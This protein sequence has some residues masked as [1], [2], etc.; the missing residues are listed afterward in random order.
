[1]GTE[2]SSLQPANPNQQSTMQT[3]H[4]LFVAVSVGFMAFFFTS[5]C[6]MA[7]Y[8][9]PFSNTSK[10][11][12]G[13]VVWVT[14]ASSGIGAS[15]AKDFTVRGAE[16]IVSAR[17]VAELEAIAKECT[18][19][20]AKSVKVLPLDVLDHTAQQAA[21]D[22]IISEFGHVD[23]LVL[24]PGRTQRA[25]AL[26]T[27]IESTRALFDLNFLSFVSLA[28]IVIPDMLKRGGGSITV[29]SSISGKMGTPVSSTYSAT[30]Y[31]LHGYFDAVRAEY[32]HRGL[33][34]L[35]VCPG[36]VVSEIAGHAVKGE[37]MEDK[38]YETEDSV[39]MSTARCTH[40]IMKAL[41]YKFDE[42]WLS[43]QPFLFIT[44]L[45]VYT[46]G[47]CRFLFKHVFGPARV[48]AF[49]SDGNVFDVMAAL[50]SLV[51]SK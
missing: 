15:L 6:D 7:L 21:Y 47:L 44:Y 50:R 11:F 30:K 51:S 19:L 10:T 12:N 41:H 9:L 34:V 38:V 17:R 25:L 1:M 45:S 39:K 28:K 16:V 23:T 26:D 40:L 8:V 37:G 42:V 2:E 13:K 33:H 49:Q 5:D 36:P 43:T 48:K 29:I 14:G 4:M 35:M 22:Q 46:P 24:N 18:A 32:A 20:G 3:T 27:T 31:A